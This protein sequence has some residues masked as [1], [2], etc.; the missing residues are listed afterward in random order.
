MC[1]ISFGNSTFPS[2]VA[3]DEIPTE[4]EKVKQDDREA[5]GATV[6]EKRMEAAAEHKLKSQSQRKGI[7]NEPKVYEDAISHSVEPQ[8]LKKKGGK[9]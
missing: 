2:T 3:M 1:G 9:R 6:S 4:I 5:Y 7:L 8:E